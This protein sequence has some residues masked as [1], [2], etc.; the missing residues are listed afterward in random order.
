MVI[1]DLL[2][3]KEE[4]RFVKDSLL[5]ESEIASDILEEMKEVPW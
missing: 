1:F 5:L 4:G 2:A 3:A